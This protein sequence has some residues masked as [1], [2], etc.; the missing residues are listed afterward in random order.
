MNKLQEMNSILG[1]IFLN[2]KSRV[3]ND[4]DHKINIFSEIR[5]KINVWF[6][7][8]VEEVKPNFAFLC[9]LNGLFIHPDMYSFSRSFILNFFFIVHLNFISFI[10]LTPK[11]F[12]FVLKSIPLCQYGLIVQ[13]PINECFQVCYRSRISYLLPFRLAIFLVEVLDNKSLY[14]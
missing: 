11:G 5:K 7:R 10:N 3:K 9:I 13:Y 14:V 6:S 8:L 2:N 12:R 1:Y 4:S